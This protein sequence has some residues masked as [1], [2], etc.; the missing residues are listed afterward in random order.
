MVEA[1]EL[2]VEQRLAALE[3]EVAQLR[4]QLGQLTVPKGDWVEQISGSMKDVPQEEWDKFMKY[5]EE[6]R[7]ADRPP[8]DQP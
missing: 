6:I 8:D 1:T 2:T 4:V 7:Y 3:K 5:C